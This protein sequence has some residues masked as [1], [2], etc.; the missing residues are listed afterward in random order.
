MHINTSLM[1][2]NRYDLKICNRPFAYFVFFFRVS[3]I[4]VCVCVGGGGGGGGG[5]GTTHYD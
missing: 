5:G 4:H 2:R 3:P 1:F